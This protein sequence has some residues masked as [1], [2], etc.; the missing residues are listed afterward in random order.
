MTRE[1]GLPTFRPG[2]RTV[3]AQANVERGHV[4]TRDSFA[5]SVM[6]DLT[7]VR[8]VVTAPSSTLLEA[9]QIMIHQ[10]IRML[11]VVN[12]A[13]TFEGLITS[14]DLRGERQMRLVAERGTH[15][16][17][18]TVGDVMTPLSSL[19]AIDI[20]HMKRATVGDV[21]TTLEQFGRDHLLVVERTAES[22]GCSVCGIVSRAQIE[23]QSGLTIEKTH[24]VS[25]FAEVERALF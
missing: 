11:F 2:T 14:T 24:M 20:E 3:V 16:D 15:F 22:G 19:D 10:G 6:T 7:K 23:R 1:K 8:A 4:V 5:L 21:I 13:A 9:E 18:L 17:E 25:T 12:A